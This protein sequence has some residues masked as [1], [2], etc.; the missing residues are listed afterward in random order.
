[1]P[2]KLNDRA[3]DNW[4]ALLAIAECAGPEWHEKAIWAAI[5]ISGQNKEAVSSSTELLQDIQEVLQNFTGDRIGTTDLLGMLTDDDIMPWLTYNRGKPMSARQLAN[6]LDA[7]DIKPTT[8]SFNGRKKKGYKTEWFQDAFGRY[9]AN[10]HETSVD[11]LLEG[12]NPDNHTKTKVTDKKEATVTEN[13]SV[14]PNPNN[15]ANSNTTTDNSE[16]IEERAA[17]MEFDGG[18]SREEAEASAYLL[19]SG[20]PND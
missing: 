12:I 13:Q 10:L 2:E 5:Q 1:M 18:L 8:I 6:K 14:T 7:F 17:I 4:E 9:L 15:I 20:A 19:H 3:Q 16:D 11:T